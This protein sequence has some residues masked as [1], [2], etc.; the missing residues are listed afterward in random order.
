MR[1]PTDVALFPSLLFQAV[2]EELL[3]LQAI[4]AEDL[5]VHHDGMG[6]DLLVLPWPGGSEE[7]LCSVELSVRWVRR[8]LNPP[9]PPLAPAHVY[10]ALA[11]S[12]GTWA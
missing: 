8:P 9:P 5:D 3:A 10:L 4:Y 6:F 2:E 11:W 1:V 12:K 7:N